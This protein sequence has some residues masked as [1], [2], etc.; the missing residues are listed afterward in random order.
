MTGASRKFRYSLH[1]HLSTAFIILVAL[2]GLAIGG[3]AYYQSQNLIKNLTSE[4]FGRIAR[5]AVLST[6]HLFAPAETVVNMLLVQEIVKSKNREERLEHIDFLSRTLDQSANIVSVYIGYA[7]GDFLLLRRLPHDPSQRKE[8]AAPPDT[9][10]I[11]QSIDREGE[12]AEGSYI[13]LR[14]DHSIIEIRERHDYGEYDPR[15][16][17]WFKQAQAAKGQIKVPHYIFFTTRELG[18]TVAGSTKNGEAVVAADITLKTLSE[19]M[20][21]FKITEGSEVALVG[22][23]GKLIAY[24]DSSPIHYAVGNNAWPTQLG[25]E[26]FG[27]EV[28]ESTFEAYKNNNAAELVID[29][30]IDGRNWRTMATPVPLHDAESYILIFAAPIDE[31]LVEANEMLQDAMIGLG[32]AL[33]IFIPV[34]IYISRQVVKP[35]NALVQEIDAIQRFDFRDPITISSPIAEVD[36]LSSAMDGMKATIR[37]FLD[38]STMIASEEDF[39]L[40]QELLLDETID[41]CH[42][43]GATLYLVDDDDTCLVPS[44]VRNNQRERVPIEIDQLPLDDPGEPIATAI[45]LG[46][47]WQIQAESD[48]GSADKTLGLWGLGQQLGERQSEELVAVPLF[49]RN[50]QLVG[51]LVLFMENELA[52]SYLSFIR[53][54]SGTAAVAIESRHLLEIQKNLFES[55]IRMIAGAIDAKSPYTGGHCERVPELTRLLASAAVETNSGS[56]ND[57]SLSEDDWEAVYIASWLHDCGKVTTP[58]Y[59]VDKATKLETIYDRIHEIRLRF[60]LLKRDAE[61]DY[62]QAMA[63]GVGQD[64]AK[65]TLKSRLTQLDDDFAFIAE[66]NEGSEFLDD[67][68][69]ARIHKI[70]AYKWQRTLDNRLGIS[71]AEKERALAAGAAPELPVEEDLICD[72]PEHRFAR[73]E[74]Q[75]FINDNSWG[76]NIDVPELLYNRGELHNLLIQ[77]GTLNE[78]ERYKINEHIV[79]TIVMLSRLPFP[80]H[81]RAVPEIAGGHH[82]KMNGTG[83]PRKLTREQMSPVARMISIADIFEALTAIDRP[84]KKGKTLN[85]ALSIMSV[86]CKEQHIDA[87]LFALFLQSGTYREYAEMYL[88]A[89][90]IKDIDITDYLPTQSESAN[91]DTNDK[92]SATAENTGPSHPAWR[93]DDR[94]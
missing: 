53:A 4:T 73:N 60:E 52:S 22:Q 71:L 17:P 92:V 66:C 91:N 70:A 65:A 48:P 29:R 55:F 2:V 43:D 51:V 27:S 30:E 39:D 20:Q 16:R 35:I 40:L 32:I 57:F 87:E 28:L 72:R 6:S 58:E 49:N 94:F 8:F 10:Y 75:N 5:E 34:S 54:L 64:K 14:K 38:I 42:A 41:I 77:R 26:H 80:K 83:Y 21:A 50:N 9:A 31:L 79:Q 62:W 78:E 23:D 24:P 18:S 93:P 86:M 76:F 25:L 12:V 89:W 13:Y 44:V 84:Y 11:A 15:N 36:D 1:V 68:K 56:L 81:L 85:E 90:Q 61:I 47:P 33:L 3:I 67:D 82:E 7:D 63:E 74:S 19:A 45:K 88:E 69:V 37:R 59:V 46:K